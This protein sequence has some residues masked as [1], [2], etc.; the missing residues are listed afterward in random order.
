MAAQ[1]TLAAVAAAWERLAPGYGGKPP[2]A[3]EGLGLAAE[4]AIFE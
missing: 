2:H 4:S 3:E 1:A